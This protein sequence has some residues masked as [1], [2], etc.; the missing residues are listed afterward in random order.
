MLKFE[1]TPRWVQEANPTEKLQ[2]SEDHYR[3][4]HTCMS[5]FTVLYVPEPG[6]EGAP[7]GDELLDWL[8]TH[9]VEPSTEEGKH[10]ATLDKPWED[11]TYW[12][13]LTR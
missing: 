3:Q 9:F 4:L 6:L 10:L 11:E 7:V 1:L 8:N 2:Y 13:Y 12:L 5:L